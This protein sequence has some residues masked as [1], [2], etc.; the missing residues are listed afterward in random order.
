[1]PNK[2][3]AN[4]W[5]QLA[6]RNIDA[7]IILF[8]ERHFNDIV[9]VE[10][11]QGIEKCFK[12]IPAFHNRAIVRT[13]DLIALL[14]DVNEFIAFDSDMTLKLEKAT[15]YYVDKRYPGGGINFLP[16]DKEVEELIATANI[17]FEK[18][19]EYINEN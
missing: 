14:S 16:D 18:V 1:M 4:E 10:L 2:T 13:H 12:A 5:L 17:I 6:K 9:A 11:H 3:I 8:R 7:G 19:Y 15:D